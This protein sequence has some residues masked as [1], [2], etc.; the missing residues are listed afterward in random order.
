[1]TLRRRFC[2]ALAA[3]FA[4]AL[5]ARAAPLIQPAEKVR[6]YVDEITAVHITVAAD[7]LVFAR[8]RSDLAANARDYVTLAPLE[9]NR[10]GKRSYYWSGYLW[11]TIDRRDG[12]P[13][14]KRGDQLVLIADGRPIPLV[15]DDKPLREHGVGQTP[16]R[17][18]VRS[19]LPVLF[20]ADLE[21]IDYVAHATE[22]HVEWIR[23]GTSE[24]LPLWKDGRTGLRAFLE[25][26]QAGR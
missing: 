14:L 12:D 20:A 1:M 13:L 22:V 16:V 3:L 6:E 8:E 4:V 17:V 7:P 18:P 11:T 10:T 25:R 24:P 9:I 2:A 23:E 26:L 5:S 15:S 21:V 19:A